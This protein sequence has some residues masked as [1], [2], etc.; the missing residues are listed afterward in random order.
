MN[1]YERRLQERNAKH[2]ATRKANQEARLIEV[3]A[4]MKRYENA[5][6][7]YY[8]RKTKAHHAKGWFTVHHRKVREER[9]LQ[10]IQNLE[11]LIHQQE[12]V[13]DL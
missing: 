7:D 2:A 10:M 4:L 1:A 11:V 12:Q 5:Y 13:N 9:F 6:F 3:D 8:G